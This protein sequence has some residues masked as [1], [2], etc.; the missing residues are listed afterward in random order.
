MAQP[1]RGLTTAGIVQLFQFLQPGFPTDRICIKIPATWE[2]LMACYFLE[3]SGVRTLATIVFDNAQAALAGEVGCS[4][5][6]PYVN[7]LKVH[8]E[9]GFVAL[10][11]LSA[12]QLLIVTRFK[13]SEKLIDFCDA[14]QRHYR[15]I[16]AKTQ[17]LPASLTSTDE[18][19]ALA[20]ANHI[21]IAS[22]LL[23]QLS[24]PSAKANIPSV[25]DAEK[26]GFIIDTEAP[27]LTRQ[28]AFLLELSMGSCGS[29]LNEVG[30][31]YR[32]GCRML[33]CSRP[34]ASSAT[35]RARLRQWCTLR[36]MTL[37]P[38]RSVTGCWTGE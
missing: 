4:Y 31:I 11:L 13:D 5:V 28:S 18:I 17:V 16:K 29:K 12:E 2:G 3:R 21:T 30:T 15:F 27:Y 37:F 8:F 25:F 9:P 36:H 32:L 33:T 7:Q 23:E 20:G 38:E 35:C 1:E 26:P 14:V 22:G 6:A 24:K 10:N 34:S 19:F